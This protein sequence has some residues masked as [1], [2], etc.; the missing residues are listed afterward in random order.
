MEKIKEHIIE[1]RPTLGGSSVNTYGSILKSLYTKVFNDSE[2]NL[3]RFS[4]DTDKVLEFL[5]DMPS[6]KRK[7]I[8]S[9]LVVITDNKKYRDLMLD[10]VKAYNKEIET[11]TKTETQ[12]EAWVNNDEIKIIFTELKSNAD[13]LYKK[14]TISNADLQEIQNYILF[15]LVSGLMIPPRRSKDWVDFKIK[16]IDKDK[17]N[18]IEKNKIVFN[19]YKTAKTYGQQ[20]VELPKELK[21]ILAKWIKVNPTEYLLFDSNLNKLSSVKLN[22]RLNKIFGKKSSVNSLRHTYLTDKYGEMS[23]QNKKLENDMSA[24]GSSKEMATQYIKLD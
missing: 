7:T 6:N 13:M 16:S 24:M 17:D 23:K 14:K 15:S 12:K 19:S 1:K 10:D 5:K 20:S 22:Q 8:L 2:Y 3:E 21:S 9:A 18:Y 11:Q 4:K